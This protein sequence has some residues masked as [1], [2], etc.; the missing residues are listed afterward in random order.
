M[1]TDNNGF[2]DHFKDLFEQTE[3]NPPA[4]IW[5]GIDKALAKKR[6]RQKQAAALIFSFV[7][8]V[9]FC[10]RAVRLDAPNETAQGQLVHTNSTGA[11]NNFL[12]N[13]L[14]QK[15]IASQGI[16]TSTLFSTN[17]HTRHTKKQTTQPFI[18]RK[19]HKTEAIRPKEPIVFLN[20]QPVHLVAHQ[21]L[22]T[23]IEQQVFTSDVHVLP[24]G[25]A[26]AQYNTLLLEKQKNLLP[27]HAALPKEKKPNQPTHLISLTFSLAPQTHTF[28]VKDYGLYKNPMGAEKGYWDPFQGQPARISQDGTH[29][30]SSISQILHANVAISRSESFQL[31]FMKR[32][33]LKRWGVSAGITY[34][35]TQYD[36]EVFDMGIDGARM[37]IFDPYIDYLHEIGK[38]LAYQPVSTASA[39]V[40]LGYVRTRSKH[41]YIGLPIEISRRLGNGKIFQQ[42]Y[43]GMTFMR[44]LQT[45]IQSGILTAENAQ[46]AQGF[47]QQGAV[48]NWHRT[49]RLGWA[50]CVA[51]HP[52]FEALVAVEHATSN[53]E[54]LNNQFFRSKYEGISFKLGVQYKL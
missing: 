28:S 44:H 5:R 7:F 51:Y 20:E 1:K 34:Q 54:V 15:K 30:F 46:Y 32:D 48:S 42:P 39:D 16:Q 10:N 36:I 52:K 23:K 26:D 50:T 14:Q 8:L 2:E 37:R 31:A 11:K 38:R 4:H 25:L 29:S 35:H 17:L 12:K 41:T 49:Y 21:P 27:A 3:I 18:H 19:L 40:Q 6:R 13:I 22:E 33:A 45:N 9:F 47:G 43:I 24:L 53:N